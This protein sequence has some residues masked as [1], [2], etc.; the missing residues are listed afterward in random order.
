MLCC[1][2][3]VDDMECPGCLKT[4]SLEEKGIII[5]QYIFCSSACL[6]E[7][8]SLEQIKKLYNV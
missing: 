4:F 5:K 7:H 1:I 2:F 8:F 6:F 3:I